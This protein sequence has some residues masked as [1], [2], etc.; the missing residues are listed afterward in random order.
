M[1]GTNAS[2][3]VGGTFRCESGWHG[4]PPVPSVC[5]RVFLSSLCHFRTCG[6]NVL[7]HGNV[8]TH[9]AARALTI[10]VQHTSPP[11]SVPHVLL[12]VPSL[13]EI[14]VSQVLLRARARV[15]YVH[16]HAHE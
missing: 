8:R 9:F 14:T 5:V 16:F 12:L 4:G 10:H 15:A 2:S 6:G 1:R 13:T 11:P 3:N 7:W